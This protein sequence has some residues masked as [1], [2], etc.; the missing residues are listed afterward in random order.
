MHNII[1]LHIYIA[2]NVDS[3]STMFRVS[4]NP[5][6]IQIFLTSM[7]GLIYFKSL[8]EIVPL[9]HCHLFPRFSAELKIMYYQIQLRC[10]SR[11]YNFS[12]K[13]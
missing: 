5:G 7:V 3:T 2:Y 13:I 6:N 11:V 12:F 4:N 8:F 9:F 1:L 10:K